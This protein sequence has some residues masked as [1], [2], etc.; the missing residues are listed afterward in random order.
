M[1]FSSG[2]KAL[3]LVKYTVL[4]FAVVFTVVFLALLAMV[5]FEPPQPDVEIQ[6]NTKFDIERYLFE[7]IPKT[8]TI[9]EIKLKCEKYYP[10]LTLKLDSQYLNF[11]YEDYVNYT[12]NNSNT[13]AKP[14]G[15]IPP[16]IILIP[17]EGV[18]GTVTPYHS[19][20]G[21]EICD[22]YNYT[23]N[24]SNTIVKPADFIPPS[25]GIPDVGPPIDPAGGKSIFWEDGSAERPHGKGN[26]YSNVYD[27]LICIDFVNDKYL[28]YN[29]SNYTGFVYDGLNNTFYSADIKLCYEHEN[30]TLYPKE[31]KTFCFP[32][33]F[34]NFPNDQKS[35]E[36]TIEIIDNNRSDLDSSY[37][38]ITKFIN[39]TI[40]SAKIRNLCNN[41]VKYVSAR[42][43]DKQLK[44][45]SYNFGQ[46]SA[47]DEIK[48]WFI[49]SVPKY[50]EFLSTNVEIQNEILDICKDSIIKAIIFLQGLAN[51]IRENLFL[52]VTF[53]YAFATVLIAYLTYRSRPILI[54]AI[55]EHT[56]RL[57]KLA[58]DWLEE[59]KFDE[60]EKPLMV[61]KKDQFQ[62][63]KEFLFEDLKL[64]IPKEIN[65]LDLWEKFKINIDKYNKLKYELYTDIKNYIEHQTGLSYS[66]EENLS[67]SSFNDDYIKRIYELLIGIAKGHLPATPDFKAKT[68]HSKVKIVT[69]KEDEIWELHD[70]SGKL[71]AYGD[72]Y[73]INSAKEI[74]QTMH[75]NFTNLE[76]YKSVN[77]LIELE[78]I[79]NE[80]KDK[81]KLRIND[82]ISIPLYSQKCKYIKMV[83]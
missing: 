16:G 30:F 43:P 82:F 17:V 25:P 14:A 38:R 45:I 37:V 71:L 81:L 64:H 44:T 31:E 63:E 69:E 35:T 42:K 34:S 53:L 26:T 12:Y 21:E 65:M 70:S 56:S 11:S 77:R 62:I 55:E 46:I 29:T 72:E 67:L 18:I 76:F 78:E 75:Q 60:V 33:D 54:K 1:F 59:I 4:A 80:Q 27:G 74:G 6:A 49:L 47:T 50:V 15:F 79:L 3:K 24:N 39:I 52:F 58:E 73:Q 23:Y 51:A 57:R 32:I 40:P 41:I 61:L 2:R 22:N 68:Y 19:S 13:I 83:K 7:D 28:I 5:Y 9:L 20:R 66:S 10:D 48:L 36:I 8:D